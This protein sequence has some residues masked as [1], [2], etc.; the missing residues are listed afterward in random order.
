MPEIAEVEIMSRQLA[1]GV[2]GRRL[3]G[4]ETKDSAFSDR[5]WSGLVGRTVQAVRR[6]GK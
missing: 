6:R 4:V 5:D 3:T 2:R 1:G